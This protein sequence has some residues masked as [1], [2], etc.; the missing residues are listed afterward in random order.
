MPAIYQELISYTHM[1]KTSGCEQI[2]K[3][4]VWGGAD[5]I[6]HAHVARRCLAFGGKRIHRL[7]ISYATLSSLTCVV[8][9]KLYADKVLDHST[10]K[11]IFP[12]FYLGPK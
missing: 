4:L 11:E 12:P 1:R 9:G 3:R 5:L 6:A 8:T 7:Y 2:R 10:V